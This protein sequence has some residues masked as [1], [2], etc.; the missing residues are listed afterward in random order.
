MVGRYKPEM[1]AFII[2]NRI[3]LKTNNV[4]MYGDL[5]KVKLPVINH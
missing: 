2:S 3:T 5:L 1:V 4:I